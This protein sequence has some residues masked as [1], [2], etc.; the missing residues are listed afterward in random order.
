VAI[1]FDGTVS[2]ISGAG[3]TLGT[4][5]VFESASTNE[6]T[7]AYN[8]AQ[9][10]ILIAYRDTGNSNFGTVIV[11]N[12]SASSIS[13]GTASV[14]VSS[15]STQYKAAYHTGAQRVV[16]AFRDAG[17]VPAN[18]GNS[19]SFQISGTSAINTA[20]A[21]FSNNVVTNISITYDTNADR[22][23]VAYTD[24]TNSSFGTVAVGTVLASSLSY[25]TPVVFRSAATGNIAVEYDAN[26][27]KVVIA[28]RDSTGFGTAIVGTVSGTS[29]SF[30]TP[31]V[32]ESAST[33]AVSIAYNSDAQKVVIAYAD[34]GNGSYGTAIVGTVSGTSISFGAA[35]VFFA[36]SLSASST[37]YDPSIQRVV[38]SYT[39]PN[40]SSYGTS[41]AGTVTG[42]SISFA[43]SVV[44]ESATTSA[45]A[46]VYA[47]NVSRVVTAYT[48][49]GNSSFGTAVPF[50]AATSNLGAQN[51]IG[52]SN[53]A[54]TDGQTATIQIVGSVDDAQS[55][56]VPGK[57]YFVQLNGTLSLTPANPSVFAGT[58]VA[59][60][61]IIVKG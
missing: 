60:T 45:I 48:D 19:N 22:V 28:Y 33:S 41:V 43:Q 44:F 32:F 13:F 12:V 50:R 36:G 40:N 17:A 58:A 3:Q 5:V 47:P 24:T 61:Q 35:S 53:A 54:Y 31:V 59:A 10:R 7:V 23:V 14:F 25:G 51:F 39:D 20:V 2:A 26:A 8:T 56:L 15:N 11:G 55:S 30:G 16:V 1:N 37:T 4:P 27:Q 38:V 9:S 21:K 57:S 6:I 52:F 29:I 42:T 18:S 49:G 34:S 46:S